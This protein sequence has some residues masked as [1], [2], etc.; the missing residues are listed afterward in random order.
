VTLQAVPETQTQPVTR[1]GM[2]IAQEIMTSR[3]AKIGVS[4]PKVTVRGDEVVIDFVSVHDAA[5]ATQIVG[6]TGRLQ[7]FDFS[8]AS[9]RRR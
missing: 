5:K 2:Q 6:N 8:R 7:F 1:Q 9:S 4:S 3:L